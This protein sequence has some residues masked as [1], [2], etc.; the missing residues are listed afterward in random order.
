MYKV[1]Y[2]KYNNL[3]CKL[4]YFLLPLHTIS[5]ILYISYEMRQSFIW[6]KHHCVPQAILMH[7]LT[8]YIHD[9]ALM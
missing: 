1:I 3:H 2:K 6:G 5:R 8:N 9:L 7:I 4:L